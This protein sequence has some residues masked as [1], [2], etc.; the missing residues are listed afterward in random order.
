MGVVYA[1]V[2]YP[3]QPVRFSPPPSSSYY[4][5]HLLPPSL[6]TLLIAFLSSSVKVKCPTTASLSIALKIRPWAV[7]VL[8][9][10]F[11]KLLHLNHI[12]R[13]V[14][15]ISAERFVSVKLMAMAMANRW[16]N[17][18]I[19]FFASRD[20]LSWNLN[21]PWADILLSNAFH[22]NYFDFFNPISFHSNKNRKKHPSKLN[23]CV[24]STI[25]H[26]ESM[27]MHYI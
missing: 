25:L 26:Y 5:H 7:L 13:L 10:S 1:S 16:M 6:S 9:S 17:V 21:F 12:P 27:N 20:R 24:H 23:C 2:S 15:W 3:Q 18:I 8:S 19:I 11:V 4:H 22:S 14:L